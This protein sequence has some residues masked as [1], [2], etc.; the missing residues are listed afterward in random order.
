MN[1]TRCF[2]EATTRVYGIAR[3]GRMVTDY[4]CDAHRPNPEER[5]TWLLRFRASGRGAIEYRYTGSGPVPA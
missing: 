5:G 3:N 2:R 4:R 1:C